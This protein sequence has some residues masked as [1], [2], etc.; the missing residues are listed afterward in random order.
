MIT[1]DDVKGWVSDEDTSTYAGKVGRSFSLTPHDL[2]VEMLPTPET[3]FTEPYVVGF[4]YLD[5][6]TIT[7]F[8]ESP[9]EPD[10]DALLRR[11]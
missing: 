10:L 3:H 11:K 9:L 5:S 2:F 6:S 4:R 8:F 1:L 7:C